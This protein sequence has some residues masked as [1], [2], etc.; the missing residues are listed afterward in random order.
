LKERKD[1]RYITEIF[2]IGTSFSGRAL[3]ALAFHRL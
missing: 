3:V 2:V 1:G